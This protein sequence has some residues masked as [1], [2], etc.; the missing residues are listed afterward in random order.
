[1]VAYDGLYAHFRREKVSVL[2]TR[3]H[4]TD[5]TR[6]KLHVQNHNNT[7]G[8]VRISISISARNTR[9]LLLFVSE[10]LR[11]ATSPNT[12]NIFSQLAVIINP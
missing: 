12:E 8:P 3:T 2:I 4:H 6:T 11:I 7:F 5:I 10:N 9:V 1:M